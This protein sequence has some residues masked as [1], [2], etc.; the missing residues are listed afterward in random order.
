MGYD[1]ST[2]DTE[3]LK[4]VAAKANISIPE[5]DVEGYLAVLQSAELTTA[6][7]HA[8]PDYIDERLSPTP[9]VGGTR[10]YSRPQENDLNAWSHQTNLVADQPSSALLAGRKIVVK[11]NMSLGGVPF[12][13]GTF[14]QL[15]NKTDRYPLSPID[16]TVVKRLL[17]NGATIVG[18]GTCE[19]Y[20]LTPMSYTSANGPV[21]NP[22]LRG[23]N[24]G[25]SSSGSACLLGLR[26]AREAGVPGLEGSGDDVE[27]ALG[28]DQAGSIRGPASYCGV[29]G[30]KPTYGLVPYTGIAGLHP[31]I[32]HAGPMALRLDDIAL[33]LQVLAGYDGL[34]GRMTPETPLREN[35]ES[36]YDKLQAFTGQQT[37]ERSLRVG[38][39]SESLNAPHTSP[40]VAKVVRDA[41]MKHFTAAGAT[42]SDVSVP[43]HLLG[44]SI[45]TASCRNHIATL[46]AGCRVPDILTHNLPQWTPRWPPDQEMFDLLT[47]HN[48]AVIH[49]I[50]GETMLGERFGPEAQAKAHRHV[51]Q[52]RKAY[53]DALQD[54][55]VLVTPTVTTVAPPHPD[56]RP[57]ADGGSSVLDKA[58]LA[59]GSMNNTC[60]FN[61]TGH[62]ALSVP[63]GWAA[64]AT[65]DARN[66]LPVGMQLV[67]RRWDDLGVLKAA[68]VFEIGGGG[69]GVWP[70]QKDADRLQKL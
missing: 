4:R 37:K 40:E 20:S 1:R 19:N 55:D 47:H 36:Y 69:L 26:R 57:A 27:M 35:V 15:I 3:V 32:D 45:W 60:Q 31:M 14:P 64:A 66:M 56:M 58:K 46:G 62:P 43:M 53:D 17:E 68:K 39:I 50:L 41:A 12:T 24:A 33:L 5:H 59:L 29:Y 13:C 52:L 61:A 11:D 7:V 23:H 67:G 51:F 25:G 8:L 42:V 22:W 16:A 63:C 9:T 18:T 2:V 10:Q 44:P 6:T 38:I 28:G 34:D 65:S 54:F 49:V 48:P 70:G 30:L 21:H